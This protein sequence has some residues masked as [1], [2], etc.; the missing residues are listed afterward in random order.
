MG[1]DD[2]KEIGFA[3]GGG[4]IDDRAHQ[5]TSG[6][7]ALD[8]DFVGVAVSAHDELFDGGDEVGEGVAL[9]GHLAGVVPRV[10]QFSSA[11]DVGVGHDDAAVEQR[12]ARGAESDW[13]GVAI[14]PVAVDIE[15]IDGDAAKAVAAVDNGDGDQS[16]VGGGDPEALGCVVGGIE[17][18]GDLLL[19]EQQGVADGESGVGAGDVVLV[20]RGRRDE[21]LVAVAEDIGGEDAVNVRGCGVGGLGEGDLYG[22]FERRSSRSRIPPPS[23]P[24][25][26]AQGRSGGGMTTNRW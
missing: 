11:A 8:G 23:T 18:A 20:D 21:R 19:L 9:E 6:A 25:R 12:E 16:A 7:A 5:E 17:A 14:R 2:A 26:H 10:A 4:E 24:L 1:E 3:G 22:R 15:G 13:E